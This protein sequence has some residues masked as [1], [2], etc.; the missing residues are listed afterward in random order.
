MLRATKILRNTVGKRNITYNIMDKIHVIQLGTAVPATTRK[1]IHVN[2]LM[3]VGV[4]T[5]KMQEDR[6]LSELERRG[7]SM[8]KYMFLSWV[9][10]NNPNL[11]YRLVINNLALIAPIIYT[12]T[13]GEVCLQ[14]SNVYP[15]LS[16]CDRVN[17]L[18]ISIDEVDKMDEIVRN[19]K[20]HS[21][22][23]SQDPKICVITDGS[24]ILGLGDLGVNGMG[25]PVGKLQ[26]YVAGAGLNPKECLPIIVDFGTNNQAYLNDSRYLGLRR[27]RP[28]DDLFYSAMEKVITGLKKGFP[29]MFIQFEDFSTDHAFGLLRKWREKVMCFNDDI[30]GTGAVIMAG[31]INA[32]AQSGLPAKE[33]RLLFVGAGSAA[34]GVADTLRRCIMTDYDISE[35]DAKK[36]FWLT[37]TKGLVTANRGDKLAAQKV[38]YARHDNGNTQCKTLAEVVKYVK[39]TVLIGLSTVKGEFSREILESVNN[40]NKENR[41]IVFPL[42]NPETKAECTFAE[43]MQ[44]TNNRVIFASGTAFPPYTVPGTNKT[45]VPGQGN[46]M[47]IFPSIGLGSVL[48][49]PRMVTD[50]AIYALSKALANSLNE[51]EKAD[52]NLYPSIDRLRK[53]ALSLTAAIIHQFVVEG[54][55]QDEKWI[56]LVKDNTDPKYL[57]PNR[58]PDGYFC[59]AL[60]EEVNRCS[61]SPTAEVETFVSNL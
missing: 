57:D 40:I 8:D 14:Y 49:K 53:V 23:S 41:P 5:I 32:I 48:A 7:S 42:S 6:A 61:W 50:T 4:D 36:M 59:D 20:E 26:L 52:G 15:F 19:Y 22:P 43:A 17:G 33:H 10:N 54:L 28:D 11:F 25:I 34:I 1:K 44:Y 35:D 13:I 55:A 16:P 9:R 51:Q 45:I 38:Y 60:R 56:A 29:D 2:G 12:P 18:Y 47:Y 21:E 58:K 24:R 46:N 31:F 3:P 39:P 37:D 27:A 30:Q